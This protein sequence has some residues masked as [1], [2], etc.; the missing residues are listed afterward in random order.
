[1]L[2]SSYA[3]SAIMVPSP[4]SVVSYV[5]GTRPAKVIWDKTSTTPLIEIRCVDEVRVC[6]Q[7]LQG[8]PLR[9]VR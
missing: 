8:G 1:M 5:L 4:G 3:I 2:S 9:L 6:P 7:T